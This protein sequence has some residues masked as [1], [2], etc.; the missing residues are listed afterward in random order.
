MGT[1]LFSNTGF[2]LLPMSPLQ[3]VLHSPKGKQARWEE[4]RR[5]LW[6]NTFPFSSS[7]EAVLFGGIH[8][9][10]LHAAHCELPIMYLSLFN[11]HQQFSKYNKLECSPYVTD[12]CQKETKDKLRKKPSL[13]WER[14]KRKTVI[15]LLSSNSVPYLT[16]LGSN[17]LSLSFS[18]LF[19]HAPCWRLAGCQECPLLPISLTVIWKRMGP[20]KM[21]WIQMNFWQTYNNI[22]WL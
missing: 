1:G 13:Q 4:L 14:T 5:V 19:F 7:G 18:A 21:L 16:C 22:F 17:V 8:A 10:R 6:N 3:K 11:V 9:P 2:T 12:L 20:K 15:H